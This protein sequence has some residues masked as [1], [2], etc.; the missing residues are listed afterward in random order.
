MDE[1]MN[2]ASTGKLDQIWLTARGRAEIVI[3]VF[4][5]SWPAES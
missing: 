3:S 4:T 1:W 2:A 5:S